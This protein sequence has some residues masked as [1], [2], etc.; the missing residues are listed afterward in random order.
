M[1]LDPFGFVLLGAFALLRFLEIPWAEQNARRLRTRG[2]KE[3]DP[4]HYQVLVGL[5][6]AFFAGAFVEALKGPWTG[7]HELTWPLLGIFFGGVLLRLWVHGTLRARWTTR[8]LVVPGEAPIRRGPYRFLKHPNYVAV[9]LEMASLP[10]A[11][12]LW[13]SAVLFNGLLGLAL[14]RRIRSEEAAWRAVAA[15]PLGSR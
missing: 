11:L 14:R 15:R 13:V 8:I 6:V 3:F 4:L 12:G 1:S 9:V 2:A 7:R 5:H 10:F